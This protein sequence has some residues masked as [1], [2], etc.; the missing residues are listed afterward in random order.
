[1]FLCFGAMLPRPYISNNKYTN[2]KGLKRGLLCCE[3]RDRTSDLRVMSPTSYRCSISRYKIETISLLGPFNFL[4]TVLFLFE[5]GAKVGFRGLPTK[6]NCLIL[7]FS[8]YRS[9]PAAANISNHSIT[10]IIDIT[11]ATGFCIQFFV[12]AY[13][14][15]GST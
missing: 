3:R 9:P 11:S 12:D 13:P 5:W 10:T 7:C 15:I 6:K 14:N 2:N 1:L 8:F 4:F